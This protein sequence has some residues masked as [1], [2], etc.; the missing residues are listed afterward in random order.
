MVKSAEK[1]STGKKEGEMLED[2][3]RE[4]RGIL[5]NE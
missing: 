3:D 4:A 1:R 2:K 5:E